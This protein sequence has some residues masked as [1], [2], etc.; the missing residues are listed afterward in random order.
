M[1]DY[2][3]D[4]QDDFHVSPQGGL[5]LVDGDDEARQR[6]MRRLCTAVQGYIWH[7][8]YGAG[9]PQKI[10]DPWQPTQIE[11]ICREQANMEASVAPDPP[12]IVNVTEVIPGMVSID[13]Q[14]ISAK[15]GAAV[16]F[17]ITV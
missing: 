2:W 6:L 9:L 8:E 15:T 7:P 17:N 10:G 14:Y 4:W 12:P 5:T 13:I 3:L 16:Q 11:A 1:T